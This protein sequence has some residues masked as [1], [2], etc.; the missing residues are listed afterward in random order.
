MQEMSSS[1]VGK[2]D[3]MPPRITTL[4]DE[5]VEVTRRSVLNAVSRL[6]ATTKRED[7]SF[8]SVAAEAQVSVR[9]VYRHF[10]TKE[11]LFDAHWRHINSEIKLPDI[12]QNESELLKMIPEVFERYS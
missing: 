7:I 3:R 8:A 5:H 4:R 9:T 2:T 1:T 10:S 6:L 11:A 12:P